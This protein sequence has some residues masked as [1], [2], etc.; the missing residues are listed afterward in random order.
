MSQ[1]AP[2]TV[3]LPTGGTAPIDYSGDSPTI[4]IRLQQA[5]GWDRTPVI[6]DARV[7]LTLELLSPARRLLARTDDLESF[8]NGPYREV[9]AQMRGRY[10]KHAWPQ[11]PRQPDR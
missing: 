10:V 11:D 4:Q 7:P 3:S 5:F 8:W 2:A 9:R 6:G 1:L